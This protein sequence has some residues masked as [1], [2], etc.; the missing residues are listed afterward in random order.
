MMV[1]R[2]KIFIP[3]I[4]AMIIVVSLLQFHHHNCDGNIF[5]ALTPDTDLVIGQ[6]RHLF[7]DCHHNE[8]GHRHSDTDN[9]ESACAFHIGSY[10][11]IKIRHL[12]PDLP[13]LI[14]D[15][16]ID[17]LSIGRYNDE[18]R[19]LSDL[20]LHQSVDFHPSRSVLFRGPPSVA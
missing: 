7:H 8:C 14:F 3:F 19:R 12:L 15:Y 9:A 6:P 17:A 11:I 2:H 5:V 4:A 10:E 13:I 16:V 1:D 18:S 20:V